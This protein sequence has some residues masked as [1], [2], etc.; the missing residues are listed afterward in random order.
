MTPVGYVGPIRA[1]LRHDGRY[2]NYYVRPE[3]STAA[4][5]PTVVPVPVQAANDS[6]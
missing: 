4:L 1:T 6:E 5:W 2:E 3:E